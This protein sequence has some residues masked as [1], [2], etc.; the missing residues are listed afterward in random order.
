MAYV[1]PATAAFILCGACTQMET[2][3]SVD[4]VL[5]A[6]EDSDSSDDC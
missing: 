2:D 4:F 5:R 3:Y 6:N 1:L